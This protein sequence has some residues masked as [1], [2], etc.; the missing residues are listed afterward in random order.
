[1]QPLRHL[2]KEAYLVE[3]KIKPA[4]AREEARKPHQDGMILQ[5]GFAA[6]DLYRWNTRYTT[7]EV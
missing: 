2:D 7:V 4:C 6:F 3:A 1:M 5:S